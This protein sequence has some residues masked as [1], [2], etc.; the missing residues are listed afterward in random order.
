[1]R[2]RDFT[3]CQFGYVR[4]MSLNPEL[5]KLKKGSQFNQLCFKCGKTWVGRV[6]SRYKTCG[7]GQGWYRSTDPTW[8]KFV[9]WRNSK[10]NEKWGWDLEYEDITFPTHCPLLGYKLNYRGNKGQHNSNASIDRI[11]PTK[12]YVKGN[13]WVISYRANVLRNNASIEELELLVSNLKIFL[14]KVD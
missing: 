9:Y 3:G 8:K 1:M 2:R 4:V 7:C 12:G 6:D 14:P 10:K 11:D 13:V 5:S